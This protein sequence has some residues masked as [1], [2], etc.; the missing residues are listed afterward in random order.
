MAWIIRNQFA[1]RNLTAMQRA[2][3]ALKLKDAVAA[4]AK[5]RQGAKP[6]KHLHAPRH[7]KEN[8]ILGFAEIPLRG[9]GRVNF[10][11]GA[12]RDFKEPPPPAGAGKAGELL[13]RS[14]RGC[15]DC[16]GCRANGR[17]IGCAT[18]AAFDDGDESAR[19]V[20]SACADCAAN[21]RRRLAKRTAH[22]RRARTW[23]ERRTACKAVFGAI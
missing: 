8:P 4:D 18:F 14:R 15:C 7:S 5:K 9:A 19:T 3:L 2:E 11:V 10:S 22:S 16:G 13:K 17:R 6:R 21:G 1:R 20:A 23:A 12:E